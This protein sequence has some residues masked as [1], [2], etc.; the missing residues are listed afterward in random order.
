MINEWEEWIPWADFAA[1]RTGHPGPTTVHSEKPVRCDQI[2]PISQ[3][4]IQDTGSGE[5]GGGG[6][7]CILIPDFIFLQRFTSHDAALHR[8]S[9]IYVLGIIGH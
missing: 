7:V 3:G 1:T 4:W 8:W 5:V 2:L 9:S 6:G